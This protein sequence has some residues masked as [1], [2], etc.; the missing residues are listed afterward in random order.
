MTRYVVGFLFSEHDSVVALLRK[1]HPRWQ[2]GRLNGIGGKIEAG[3]TSVA[4]MTREFLEET[5]A[6]E[7]PEWTLR[8]TLRGPD[9]QVEFFSAH[10]D[11]GKL[12]RLRGRGD[13]PVCVVPVGYLPTDTI[14]NLRWLIPLAL[15]RDIS[16]AFAQDATSYTGTAG[17]EDPRAGADCR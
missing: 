12:R 3:E 6:T 16:H 11:V 7:S 17:M 13:E 1:S 15:D 9:W 10:M 5:T 8:V 4:A 2:A 14:P